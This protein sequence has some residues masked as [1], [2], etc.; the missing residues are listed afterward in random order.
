MSTPREQLIADRLADLT[1]RRWA[2]P[3]LAAM[4]EPGVDRLAILRSRLEAPRGS[5]IQAIDHKTD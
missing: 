5:L 2:I 3:I 4:A 1:H